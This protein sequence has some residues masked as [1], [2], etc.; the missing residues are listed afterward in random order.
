MQPGSANTAGGEVTRL[1]RAA[2]GGDREALDRVIPLLYDDLRAIARRQLRRELGDRT[3]HATA[4][5]HEAYLKLSHGAVLTADDRAHFLAIAARAM[6]QVMVDDARRR[7]AA[8]RGVAWEHTTLGE[9][10]GAV[11]FSPDEMLTLNDALERLDPRQRQVVECRYFGGMEDKE[12]AAAL[13]VTERTV[14][15]DWV[16]ARAWL[17]TALYGSPRT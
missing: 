7:S 5:V 13:G 17:Y 12:I 4:L 8:K 9:G 15:R 10:D 1:L 6:R 3:M 2:R 11:A 16:K 14:R